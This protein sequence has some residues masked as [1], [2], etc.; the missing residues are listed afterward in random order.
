VDDI[1][2][3]DVKFSTNQVLSPKNLLEGSFGI[4]VFTR[5]QRDPGEGLLAME[6]QVPLN[7]GSGP[8]TRFRLLSGVRWANPRELFDRVG[9]RPGMRCLDVGC[10]AGEVTLSMAM[11][12]GPSGLAVG[13]DHEERLLREARDAAVRAGLAPEFHH[14]DLGELSQL[15]K[16]DLVYMRFLLSQRSKDEARDALARMTRVV[17]PGGMIVVEDLECSQRDADQRDGDPAYQRFLELFVTLIHDAGI[18]T[19]QGWELPCFFEEAG[20]SGVR[21][22]ESALVITQGDAPQNAAAAILTSIRHVIVAAQLATRSE[23]DRLVTEL[24]RFRSGSQGLSWLP[25][26][27]QVWGSVPALGRGL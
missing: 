10:G 11:L 4:E 13:V 22:H 9:L 3:S 6:F 16:F 18:G 24:D 5:I 17:R 1:S 15:G 20:L 26:I 7:R 8:A 2:R 14:G 21:C 25:R 12:V 27:V 19:R 23:I